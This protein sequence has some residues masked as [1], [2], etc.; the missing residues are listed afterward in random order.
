MHNFFFCFEVSLAELKQAMQELTLWQLWS[1]F[2]LARR[3]AVAS[4]KGLEEFAF[5]WSKYGN[6]NPKMFER[7]QSKLNIKSE[8]DD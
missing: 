2:W 8:H 3:E 6:Q 7:H 1:P 5:F 4:M